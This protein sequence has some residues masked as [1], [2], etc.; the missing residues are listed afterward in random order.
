MSR[1]LFIRNVSYDVPESTIREMFEKYGE[2]KKLFL[3]VEKRGMAFITYV[4][5]S[6]TFCV[7]AR[8]IRFSNSTVLSGFH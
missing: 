4:S 7:C 3:L 1:T 2:I 8:F 6:F 5:I